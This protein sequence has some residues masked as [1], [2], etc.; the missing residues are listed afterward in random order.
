MGL[1]SGGARPH[2]TLHLEQVPHIKSLLVPRGLVVLPAFFHTAVRVIFSNLDGIMSFSTE[3]FM[4]P[5][6]ALRIKSRIPEKANGSAWPIPLSF[7]TRAP[8]ACSTLGHRA[9][10]CRS[11]ALPGPVRLQCLLLG[12]LVLYPPSAGCRPQPLPTSQT[13]TL[14]TAFLH[15]AHFPFREFLQ[16]ETKDSIVGDLISTHP[17]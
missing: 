17:P 2:P 14:L 16:F 8:L 12:T 5:P 6:M 4:L 7:V 11:P 1:C 9:S 10:H 13:G 15:T 3:D